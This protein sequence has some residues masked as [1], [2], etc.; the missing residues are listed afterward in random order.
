GACCPLVPCA[1]GPPA[2]AFL[3]RVQAMTPPRFLVVA[4][5]ICA[6]AGSSKEQAKPAQPPPP[7]PPAAITVQ[8]PRAA[9]VSA[10]AQP[11]PAA[12]PQPPVAGTQGSG[13]GS[14]QGGLAPEAL[15]AIAS[16]IALFPDPLLG[17]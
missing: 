10:A 8:Q 4:A 12:A 15:E 6:C 11:G 5:M 17:Q 2:G 14:T 3:G 16:P 13:T 1:S 9:P 7:P